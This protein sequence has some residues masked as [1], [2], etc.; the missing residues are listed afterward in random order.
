MPMTPS[1]LNNSTETNTNDNEVDEVTEK[2][3]LKMIIRNMN[4]PGTH[5]SHL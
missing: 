3:F 2:E 1:I 5:G 4:K